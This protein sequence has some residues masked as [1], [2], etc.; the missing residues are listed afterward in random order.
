MTKGT[1][2]IVED[3]HEFRKIYGDRL[4]FGGYDVLEAGDGNEA[5][6]VVRSKKI[7]LIMTDINMPNKDGYALLSDLK[8]DSKLKDIP[9]IVMSVF[10]QGEHLEKAKSLGAIDYL[11]K[12]RTT[13]ND[14]VGKI[15]SLISA[16]H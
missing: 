9:V 3:K 12:G 15:D 13:P 8:A 7:D 11:V 6:D 2:L 1:I 14:V 4:R 16:A 5:L 10:D